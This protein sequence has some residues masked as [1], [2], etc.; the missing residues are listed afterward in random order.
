MKGQARVM[1]AEEQCMGRWGEG[2]C[3]VER[4]DLEVSGFDEGWKRR[5]GARAETKHREPNREMV[6]AQSPPRDRLP[7][8]PDLLSLPSAKNFSTTLYLTKR[9]LNHLS[10]LDTHLHIIPTLVERLK[11]EV[12]FSIPGVRRESRDALYALETKIKPFDKFLR[13]VCRMRSGSDGIE[14]TYRGV[15]AI[16]A[17]S[18]RQAGGSWLKVEELNDRVGD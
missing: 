5:K 8:S 2:D 1:R 14:K 13:E 11:F 16:V 3:R 18:Q 7:N 12:I 17:K 6:L 10:M 9:T 4:D 15:G